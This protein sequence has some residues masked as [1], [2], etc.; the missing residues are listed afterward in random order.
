MNFSLSLF[1]LAIFPISL[2]AL[3]RSANKIVT[4]PG[5]TIDFPLSSLCYL[6]FKMAFDQ[7]YSQSTMTSNLTNV[8]DNF[9][10]SSSM[11]C[12]GGGLEGSDVLKL[13]A[14]ANCYSV[15][16]TTVIN[17]PVQIGS[18]FWYMTPG[19]S[20]GFSP[21]YTIAQTDADTFDQLNSFRLSWHLDG[22]PGWRLGNLVSLYD[23]KYKKYIF[24]K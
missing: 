1:F 3:I 7:K 16:T 2:I 22:P 18:A 19:K 9:C 17:Q 8:K 14:C 23:T 15:L 6:G 13:V 10:N 4:P 5:L 11:L 21:N 24:I 20:F 12:A